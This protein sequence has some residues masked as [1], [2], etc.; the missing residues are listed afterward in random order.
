MFFEIGNIIVV[1]GTIFKEDGLYDTRIYGHP[2]LVLHAN[3]DY[4]YYLIMCSRKSKL[5]DGRQYYCVPPRDNKYGRMS[6]INCKNIY[7]KN[8]EYHAIRDT[9]E[10]ARLLDVLIKFKHYQEHVRE[11]EFYNEVKGNVKRYMR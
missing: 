11:D 7:K 9:L 2:A 6:Y 8:I 3:D 4:F 10:E 5:D 1:K